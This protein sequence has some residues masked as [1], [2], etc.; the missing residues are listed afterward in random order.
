MHAW[1]GL[2]ADLALDGGSG[3]ERGVLQR[4]RHRSIAIPV[5][6][7]RSGYAP[8]D[9][10]QPCQWRRFQVLRPPVGRE[11]SRDRFAGAVTT[12]QVVEHRAVSIGKLPARPVPRT[13]SIFERLGATIA[14]QVAGTFPTQGRMVHLHHDPRAG[15]D[16][17]P[18]VPP[19]GVDSEISA[20]H[21]FRDDGDAPPNTF[22][23]GHRDLIKIDDRAAIFPAHCA[24]PDREAIRVAGKSPGAPFRHRPARPRTTIQRDIHRI[25]V[26]RRRRGAPARPGVVR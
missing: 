13:K 21:S 22:G 6:A 12:D 8:K 16:R 18:T 26:F 5:A 25:V 11:P 24:W 23:K 2:A 14:I 17:P 3:V 4:S 7:R 20:V 9:R 19:T 10:G 15:R 1:H